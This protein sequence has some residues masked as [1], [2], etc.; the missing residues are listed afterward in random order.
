MNTQK[1]CPE[2]QSLLKGAA[3][4]LLLGTILSSDAHATVMDTFNKTK[5]L[6]VNYAGPLLIGGSGIFAF[7]IA[8]QKL[9]FWSAIGVLIIVVLAGHIIS[10]I[11][12]KG[13]GGFQF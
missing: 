9:A 13:L 8:L 5:A 12:E 11:Y 6:S 1:K 4:A 10:T 3:L 2:I 7:S